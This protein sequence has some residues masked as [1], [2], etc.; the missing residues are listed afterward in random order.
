MR[1]E[2]DF[3][4][5]PGWAT[6]ELLKRVDISGWVLEPCV[7][8]EDIAHAL[9][10]S[11]GVLGVVTNDLDRRHDA[12]THADATDAAWW[13]S[14]APVHWVVTNP[15]FTVADQILPLAYKHAEVGVA[16]LLRL[17]YMEP[18]EGRAAWLAEYPPS[19]LIVL[20]R[21]S[22]TGDGNT[23]SVTCAWM[24]WEHGSYGQSIEI[25]NIADERQGSLFAE[26]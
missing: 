15:A 26:A 16:M 19:G 6:R 20:P 22:F 23:D 9:R 7:G 4:P 5:T 13:K 14:L 17:T 18:C 10:E 2:H 25:V 12:M 1:R 21:I 8:D 11:E 3:Y 24:V